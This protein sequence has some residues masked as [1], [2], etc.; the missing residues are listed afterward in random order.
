MLSDSLKRTLRNWNGSISTQM[1]REGEQV[2]MRAVAS[3]HVFGLENITDFVIKKMSAPVAKSLMRC[4][5][6]GK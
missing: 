3:T 6:L 4:A 2:A 1:P 5:A